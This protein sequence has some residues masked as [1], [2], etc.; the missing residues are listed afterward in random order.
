M[1]YFIAYL[2]TRDEKKDVEVLEE[3]KAYLQKYLNEGKIFAKGPFLDHTGGLIIYKTD[4][5][6]EALEIAKNDPVIREG[7]RKMIF[8]AWKSTLSE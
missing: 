3:H 4:T 8:K 6:E 5:E 2:E 1:P 7:S